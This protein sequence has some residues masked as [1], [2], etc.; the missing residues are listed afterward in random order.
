[1]SYKNPKNY[2]SADFI[3]ILV[4]YYSFYQRIQY[5]KTPYFKFDNSSIEMSTK[6][7]IEAVRI[8]ISKNINHLAKFF[9]TTNL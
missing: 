4:R 1:M 6:Q 9:F 3:I 2:Q 7:A 5:F 8:P